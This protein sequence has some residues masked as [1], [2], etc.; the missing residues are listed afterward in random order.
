[1]HNPL[2]QTVYVYRE[3]MITHN[4][5]NPRVISGEIP[6]AEARILR[7]ECIRWQLWTSRIVEKWMSLLSRSRIPGVKWL[8]FEVYETHFYP[9]FP[10]RYD[11]IPIQLHHALNRWQEKVKERIALQSARSLQEDGGAGRNLRRE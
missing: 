5:N 7:A 6:I 1:M 9:V 8:V 10:E 2:T 11:V 4:K 3:G